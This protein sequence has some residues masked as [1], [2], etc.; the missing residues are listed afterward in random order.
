[1]WKT[2]SDGAAAANQEAPAYLACSPRIRGMVR[3]SPLT[4]DQILG[5]ADVHRRRTGKWPAKSSGPVL[6]G[7]EETWALVNQSLSR[8][9]RGLAGGTTLALL[10][11][12]HRGKRRH[13]YEPLLA[14][15]DRF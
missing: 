9:Y 4:V 6:D 1:M 8:G 11:A 5:W 12:E 3:H 7:P 10:L 2:S 13:M 14:I 15:P